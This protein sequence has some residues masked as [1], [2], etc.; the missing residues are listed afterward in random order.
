MDLKE[1]INESVK[2]NSEEMLSLVK[3]FDPLL[4]KYTYYLQYEDAYPDLQLKLLVVFSK[5]AEN[6][7]LKNDAQIISYIEIAIKNEYILLSKKQS[8]KNNTEYWISCQD[9]E[10]SLQNLIMAQSAVVDDYLDIEYFDLFQNL[11]ISER[12]A[13]W[14]I[15]IQGLSAAEIARQ[16]GCSRQSINQAKR[17]GLSKLRAQLE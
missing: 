5:I 9:D 13:V 10:D 14:G 11:T 2:G 17:R 12:L 15:V 1:R 3:Q 7:L 8:E 16:Q 6:D 4:K